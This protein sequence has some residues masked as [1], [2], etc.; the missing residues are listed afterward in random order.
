MV[1]YVSLFLFSIFLQI[2]SQAQRLLT[3]EEAVNLALANQ[4]NLKG[5]NLSVQQQQQLLTV[6]MQ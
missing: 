6:A 1:R 4:R 2:A 5:A 3:K